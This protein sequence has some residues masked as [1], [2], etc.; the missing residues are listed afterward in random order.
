[1]F[2]KDEKDRCDLV[3]N[4][5]I[6]C[7][8]EVHKTLGPGLLESVYEECLCFELSKQNIKFQ[9]QLS[10]PIKYKDSDLEIGYRVDLL[11]ED[12]VLIELK[13]VEK[14]FPGYVLVRMLLDDDSWLVVRT[15][16]GVT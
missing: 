5:I 4:K 7:A 12:I 1:M 3:S 8:I 13:A 6:G 10:I 16:E 14:V 2:T 15:T 9:R 11:V